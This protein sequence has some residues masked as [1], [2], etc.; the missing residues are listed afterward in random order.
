[1]VQDTQPSLTPA[2]YIDHKRPPTCSRS[3]P[4]LPWQPEQPCSPNTHES[5]HRV[6]K[7]THWDWGLAGLARR[8]A[9]GH[10]VWHRPVRP[11]DPHAAIWFGTGRS[12]WKTCLLQ[13]A[14]LAGGHLREAPPLS[15]PG[16]T[17]KQPPHWAPAD[18][19]LAHTLRT[20]AAPLKGHT[21]QSRQLTAGRW[22]ACSR[23]VART[24][25][26]AS[27]PPWRRGQRM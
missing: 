6:P 8:P 1:M 18:Q 4:G 16:G 24:S 22:P 7:C 27:R 12:G 10:L 23:P 19:C 5:Q 20:C 26:S 11:E 14:G 25:A 3:L 2:K 15:P 9:C 13:L 17:V 21:Q